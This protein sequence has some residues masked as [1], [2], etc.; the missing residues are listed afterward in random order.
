MAERFRVAFVG[1]DHPHGAGWREVL[2][3]LADEA[4]LVAHV[5]GFGGATASLE[6]RYAGTRRFDT[7]AQLLDWGNF[8]GALVCLPNTE[9]PAALAALA[10]AGKHVV[11][12]KPAAASAAE[13]EPVAEAVKRSGVAFQSGYLWR[14]DPGAGRLRDMVADGRFGKIISVEMTLATSDVGRRGPGHYLFDPAASGRGFFNWLGCHWL[15]LLPYVTGQS[16]VGVTARVGVF[17]A[18]PSALEDGGAVILDLEGGGIATLVGG[19]WLPRWVTELHWTVRGSQRWVEWQPSRPGTGGVLH[20][21]GPQPQFHAME[22]T[23]TLPPDPTPGYGGART[24]HLL[25]DWIAAARGGPDV[26]R[27][28]VGPTTAVLRL[29]DAIYRAAAEGRRVECGAGGG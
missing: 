16:V 4:E 14:Y 28:G 22:E 11:A 17:G 23:F 21:H 15:D 20:V 24:A 13:F 7:V 26:C 9:A 8:D 2:Q 27:C 29:L 10:A 5:P 25:R 12:E 6:E 1:I 3:V 19:Y 18:T